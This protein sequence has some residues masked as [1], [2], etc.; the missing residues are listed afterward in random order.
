[1]LTLIISDVHLGSRHCLIE[2][3]HR[4]LS[5]LPD[6]ATLVLNG[7]TADYHT[8]SR[9]PPRHA[10]ALDRLRQES[11]RRRVVWVR[12]NHDARYEL[13]DPRRIEMVRD[14]AVDR[15]LY[16]SHG[17]DFDNIMP[18]H[19]LFIMVFRFLHRVRIV[20]GAPSVHVALYA[21]K[22]KAL[23][24]VLQNHV[25]M[26]AVEHAKENGFAA[27]TCGHTHTIEDRMIEGIRYLNTGAWTERPLVYLSVAGDRIELVRFPE[28][29]PVERPQGV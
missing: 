17:Y 16:V 1:M 24:R 5:A 27:A 11:G 8:A 14:L 18:Y 15:R 20:L 2:E 9:M 13:R 4:F 3:F 25:A 23:Y 26:N 28:A 22:F 10:E 29:A 7:D 19:K 12:G 21:K 6:G